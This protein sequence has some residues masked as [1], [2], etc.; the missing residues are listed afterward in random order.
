M[1]SKSGV[2]VCGSKKL[3]PPALGLAFQHSHLNILAARTSLRFPSYK[4][5][6]ILAS[7][8]L[9]LVIEPPD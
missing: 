1:V 5:S 8:S 2:Y 4:S 9:C 3:A 6:R 7:V